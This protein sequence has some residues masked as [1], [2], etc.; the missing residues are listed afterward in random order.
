MKF[1]ANAGTILR[2]GTGVIMLIKRW[3]QKQTRSTW[4]VNYEPSLLFRCVFSHRLQ[5]LPSVFETINRRYAPSY[6]HVVSEKQEAI[7]S[8]RSLS[9]YQ[10]IGRT[11]RSTCRLHFDTIH[12]AQCS[13]NK[14]RRSKVTRTVLRKEAR[15]LILEKEAQI[16]WKFSF[17]H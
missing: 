6:F 7:W 14:R 16:D 2:N 11:G 12:D 13:G 8:H 3:R 17:V 10:T 5:Y 9:H 1:K 4:L 15:N